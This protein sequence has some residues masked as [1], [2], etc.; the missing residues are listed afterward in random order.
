MIPQKS[1]AICITGMH[2][3]GTSSIARIMN[4][5]GAYIGQPEQMIPPLE[6]NPK[7]FWEQRT[8][9]DFNEKLLK[10]LSRSWDSIFPL[11]ETWWTSPEIDPFRRDLVD[12][13]RKEFGSRPLWMWKDPRM[14][15]LLPFWRDV[16]KQLDVDVYYLI[17]ARNPLDV[18]TSLYR[19]NGFPKSKSLALWQLYTVSSLYW[20]NKAKRLILHYD[21]VIEDWPQAFANVLSGFD[22]TWPQDRDKEV[23]FAV[24]GFLDANLRHSRSDMESLMSDHDVP[25]TVVELYRF[26]LESERNPDLLDSEKTVRFIENLYEDYPKFVTMMCVAN[27]WEI[28]REDLRSFQ[29]QLRKKDDRILHLDYMLNEL[30]ASMKFSE[31][32]IRQKDNFIRQCSDEIARL[33]SIE[34]SVA[35][36]KTR[37]LLDIIDNRI[38][39]QDTKRGRVYAAI[40][41]HYKRPSFHELRA[42]AT[43]GAEDHPTEPPNLKAVLA[44]FLE[45]PR[46]QKLRIRK[47][48]DIIIPVYNGYNYLTEL[49]DS[50]FENTALPFR[51]IIIDDSSTDRNV[52]A[53][54]QKMQRTHKNIQVIRNEE[55][56]GFVRSISR[57]IRLTQNHFVILNTDVI[58][59]EHWLERLMYPILKLR[60]VASATPFSNAGYICS[61]PGVAKDSPLFEGLEL[62]RIDKYF[63]Q[64]NPANNYMVL[65]T[66]AGFCMGMNRNVLDKIGMFDEETFGR[67]YGEEEDWC[68]RAKEAGF[69]NVI[70]PN[71]FVSHR[72]GGSFSPEEKITLIRENSAKLFDKH[73][74][75]LGQIW[76]FISGDPLRIIRNF[77][78]MLIS[79]K[80]DSTGQDLII[81]IGN[82]PD[83]PLS[84]YAGQIR[85]EK[86]HDGKKIFL[87]TYDRSNGRYL[88][89]Y[90]YQE[91]RF[92]YTLQNIAELNELFYFVNIKNIIISE[93]IPYRDKDNLLSSLNRLKRKFN[94]TLKWAA[95]R[96]GSDRG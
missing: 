84:E 91:H 54:L 70:V 10:Y 36:K 58:V 26:I 73:P 17:C 69:K 90:Y 7:G 74:E 80:S 50:I 94:V 30:T 96:E 25:K 19:R 13:V 79:S 52:K 57:G 22:I 48:I 86:F 89:S 66:G 88:V 63:Q 8:I 93:L 27:Q 37:Q 39:P 59:P 71:L 60:N 42:P 40:M 81:H 1:K 4:I 28:M 43:Y 35:W 78:I 92:E 33:K 82:N 32:G 83:T 15:L 18:A 5:L 23:R 77:L 76:E 55:N 31:D 38:F 24:K 44:R 12:L 3:S 51:L 75:H 49:L 61:F 67:G 68:I 20:T 53:Y 41:K 45:Q 34:E 47:Q 65:P 11:Q 95:T 62:E 2:R 87:L 85:T 9:H 16:L 64:V 29:E 6:E 21:R 56:M 14:S 46:I 72:H